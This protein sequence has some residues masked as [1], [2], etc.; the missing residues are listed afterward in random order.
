M[1][2]HNQRLENQDREKILAAN[3][4]LVSLLSRIRQVFLH[5]N[6]TAQAKLDAIEAF[7]E[8]N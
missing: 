3:V 2:T 8:E 5:L 1:V 4:N 7:L 6:W